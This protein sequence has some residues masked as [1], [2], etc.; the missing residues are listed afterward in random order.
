LIFYLFA[1]KLLDNNINQ[2]WW[3]YIY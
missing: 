1:N 2:R 3:Y